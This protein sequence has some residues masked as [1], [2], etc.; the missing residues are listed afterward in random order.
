ME[1]ENKDLH[2]SWLK[3]AIEYKIDWDEELERRERLGITAPDP[4]PNPDDI[5]IDMKTGSVRM[6][7]PYTKEE[8]PAWD[9]LRARKK[10]C[11]EEI[12]YY[13]DLLKEE[14]ENW[15]AQQEIKYEQRLR[16]I[17]CRAIPD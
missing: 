5:I 10:Q 7:G 15:V 16:D 14:P 11:D 12:A 13:K 8:K 6:K 1:S 3:T 17:I 2:D 9:K 4:I